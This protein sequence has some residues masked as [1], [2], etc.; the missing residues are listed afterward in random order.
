[1]NLSVVIGVVNTDNDL[2][3]PGGSPCA[4]CPVPCSSVWCCTVALVAPVAAAAPTIERTPV[5]DTRVFPAGTRCDFEVIGHRTGTLTVKTW[6]D[7]SD[8]VRQT[9][10]WDGGRIVYTNPANGKSVTTHL[11]GPAISVPNGDGTSHTDHP[12]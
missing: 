6:S 1:M 7:G 2:H 8:V 9:F 5:D 4:T 3:K 11:A 10:T 12:G